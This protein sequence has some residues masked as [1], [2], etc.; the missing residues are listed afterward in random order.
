MIEHIELLSD[1]LACCE[2]A[3]GIKFSCKEMGQT[4]TGF[5]ESL[6]SDQNHFYHLHA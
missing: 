5:I 3:T 6:T 1:G 2:C 4:R